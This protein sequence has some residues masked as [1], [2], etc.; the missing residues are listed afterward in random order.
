MT[1]NFD[2]IICLHKKNIKGFH[3]TIQQIKK[4]LNNSRIKI[5]ANKELKN[6]I[7]KIDSKLIFIDEDHLV[8]DLTLENIKRQLTELIGIDKRSG[9]YFQQFLKMG[10]SLSENC[11]EYYL[12]CDS[13]LT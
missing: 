2:I 7:E 3:L 8:K 11:S 6:E 1:E 5:I 12:I 10:Y 13:D 4:F 9:W